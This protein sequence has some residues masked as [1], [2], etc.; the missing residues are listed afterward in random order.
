MKGRYV[1]EMKLIHTIQRSIEW[2]RLAVTQPREQLTVMQRKARNAIEVLAYCTRHLREDRAPVLAAA[3]AFRTLFG[4]LPVLVVATL[5]ARA[6]L[7]E[8]FAS[9]VGELLKDLGLGSVSIAAATAGSTPTDLASWLLSI[10]NDASKINLSALGWVGFAV[11]SLSA[12]WLLVAIEASF[13]MIYRAPTGRSWPKRVIVYWFLIT[14]GPL[15]LVGLPWLSAHYATVT[16]ILPAWEWLDDVLSII[17]GTFIFW[18]F[19]LLAYLWVPNTRVHG[20]PAM[21]GALVAAILL[22]LS[23]QLFGLYTSHALTLNQLYGSLGL[24]P[25]FM[26]WVYLMWMFVLFGLEVASILQVLRGRR[27]SELS[28]GSDEP[29]LIDPAVVLRVVALADEAFTRGEPLDIETVTQELRVPFGLSRT[30]LDRL[31]NAKIL[32]RLEDNDQFVLARPIESINAADTLAIG[33][34]I[35]DEANSAAVTT[36]ILSSLRDAQTNVLADVTLGYHES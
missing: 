12:I 10:V 7:S 24:I 33:F 2:V 20:R 5:T 22:E 28:R 35:A 14:G 27:P 23:K 36:E 15:L 31:A 17:T 3:L 29:R 26:F 4:L 16:S 18:V 30:M 1:R 13:N 11:V 32:R 21:I 6:I 19:T 8:N 34:A 9:T 25:L